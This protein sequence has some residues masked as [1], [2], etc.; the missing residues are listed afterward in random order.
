MIDPRLV[1]IG[2]W[3]LVSILLVLMGVFTNLNTLMTCGLVGL[4]FGGCA[5][6]VIDFVDNTNWE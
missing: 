4:A 6:I 2:A 1:I 3:M 5:V